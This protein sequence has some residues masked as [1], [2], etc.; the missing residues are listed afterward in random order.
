MKT[1]IPTAFPSCL[2][3]CSTPRVKEHSEEALWPPDSLP[4]PKGAVMSS[5]VLHEL[6]QLVRHD[7]QFAAAL[8]SADTTEQAAELVRRHGLKVT[9]EALW[10]CHGMLMEWERP[11]W[12]G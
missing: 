1:G 8:P 4:D 11:T 6:K 3:T 7:S 12:R 5:D 2:H 10:R 9:P